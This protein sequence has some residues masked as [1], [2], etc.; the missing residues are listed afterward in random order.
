[1]LPFRLPFDSWWAAL[2]AMPLV[3]ARAALEAI[4]FNA[5]RLGISLF[6]LIGWDLFRISEYLIIIGFGDI[7]PSLG[8][9]VHIYLLGGPKMYSFQPRVRVIQYLRSCK[10]LSVYTKSIFSDKDGDAIA[11]LL[12]LFVQTVNENVAELEM[13]VGTVGDFERTRLLSHSIKGSSANHGAAKLKSIAAELEE[14]CIEENSGK[15]AELFEEMK[16]QSQL[17]VEAV[18]EYVT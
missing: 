5:D 6:S 18:E 7:F 17:T 9:V 12:G 11:S 8:K 1:M 3:A 2:T 15:A 10:S 16:H 4:V 13:I 14:A